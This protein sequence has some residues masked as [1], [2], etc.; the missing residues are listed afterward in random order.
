MPAKGKVEHESMS[1][2][3]VAYLIL[4]W[5][6][7]RKT[8]I[9]FYRNAKRSVDVV[10]DSIQETVSSKIDW[11]WKEISDARRR[12]VRFRTITDIKKDNLHDCKK[13]MTRIDELRHLSGIGVV[14][15][16]SDI[17]FA[18]MVPSSAPREETERIQFIHSDSENVVKFEQLIFEAL[19]KR[20][21]PAQS[22]INELNGNNVETST[23]QTAKA[24]ID[25]IYLC[26]DCNKMF[27]FQEEVDDH[28][29]TTDHKNFQEYPIV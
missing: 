25:R 13:H 4:G 26:K 24:A 16:V 5:E 12:G 6:N 8:L 17:E 9:D 15:G 2:I 28:K 21:V 14:F 27:V 1:R 3:P 23:V 19:W 18:A 11:Q 20:A 29:K 7:N 22:R 10:T